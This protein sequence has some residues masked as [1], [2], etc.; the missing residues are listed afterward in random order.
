MAFFAIVALYGGLHWVVSYVDAEWCLQA[1]SI[2]L[3]I[4]MSFRISLF[5]GQVAGNLSESRGAKNAAIAATV[6]MPTILLHSN[7][8]AVGESVGWFLANCSECSI[9]RRRGIEQASAR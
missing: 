2:E 6:G 8:E 9:P 4:A 1:W 5:V 7:W 3:T